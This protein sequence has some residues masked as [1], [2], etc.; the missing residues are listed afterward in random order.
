MKFALGEGETAKTVFYDLRTCH[1]KKFVQHSAS[2]RAGK[3]C[4]VAIGA[5][6]LWSLLLPIVFFFLGGNDRMTGKVLN[7]TIHKL[8]PNRGGEGMLV[9]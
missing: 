5:N 6:P 1:L 2:E 8:R 4:K 7:G 3:R 9:Q